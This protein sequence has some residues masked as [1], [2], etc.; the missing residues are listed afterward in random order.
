MA[1]NVTAQAGRF[2]GRLFSDNGRL[3]FVIDVNTESGVAR[4]SCRIDDEQQI[5]QMPIAE[6]GLK[7]STNTKLDGFGVNA[8]PNRIVEQTDGWFFSTR[9]GLKGPYV[10]DAEADRALNSYIQSMQADS[11]PRQAAQAH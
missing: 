2:E 3:N 6:V 4:V 10:S 8:S 1:Q 9:E 5:V 11:A 7:L